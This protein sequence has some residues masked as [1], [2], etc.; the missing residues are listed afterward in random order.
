MSKTN[1]ETTE[2]L[3]SIENNDLRIFQKLLLIAKNLSKIGEMIKEIFLRLEKV[4]KT[5]GKK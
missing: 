1:K 2:F 3:K 4:E 5:V